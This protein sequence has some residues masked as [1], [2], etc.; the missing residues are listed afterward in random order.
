MLIISFFGMLSAFFCLDLIFWIRVDQLLRPVKWAIVWR[1]ILAIVSLPSM[2][3][4]LATIF[5]FHATARGHK[6]IPPL[7]GAYIYIWNFLIVG[8]ALLVLM[9]HLLIVKAK[10]GYREARRRMGL[11]RRPAPPPPEAPQALWSRRNF[12]AAT[13]FAVPPLCTLGLSEVALS[14]R[15]EFRIKNYDLTLPGWDRALDGFTIALV[16]DVHTGIF[17]TPTMLNRIAAATNDLR[18]DLIL[19]GGDLINLSHADLPSALDMV[20]KLDAPQGMYMI[21]G[22]HDVVEP[23]WDFN[24]TVRRRGVNLLV[25]QIAT[26]TPRG[27]PIQILG[28]AWFQKEEQMRVSVATVAANRDLTCFPILLAHHPHSWD[29]ATAR[30]LPLTL[31]G[32]THG[33]QIMLTKNIGGGPLRFRYWSGL[34]EQPESKLIVSNGVGNWFPIRI[35]A[36]AEILKITLHPA[37]A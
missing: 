16:A 5:A 31:S 22:N 25:D 4:M 28:T 30:G 34:Y 12:L 24:K 13:A 33:G 26:L 37:E 15:G 29:E 36:P 6:Y 11:E 8:P 27:V 17:T 3:F 32:H 18:A 1:W 23:A 9:G 20:M 19:F 2:A 14:Q 10:A 7:L 21:Q 35:N